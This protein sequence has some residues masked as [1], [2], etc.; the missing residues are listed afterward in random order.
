[1]QKGKLLL[2]Q[3]HVLLS[4]HSVK[5]LLLLAY[6]ELEIDTSSAAFS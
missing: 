5:M 4:L 1:M 6:T 2:R 3:N